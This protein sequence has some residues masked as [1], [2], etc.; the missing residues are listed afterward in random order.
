MIMECFIRVPSIVVILSTLLPNPIAPGK[1]AEINKQYRNLAS[2]LKNDDRHIIL[3][4]MD[5]GFITIDEIWDGTHPNLSG[6]RKMAAV[7]HRAIN[8]ADKEGWLQKPSSD[9]TFQDGTYGNTCPKV[10]GSGSSDP[11]SGM[12]ILTANSGLIYDDGNYV[13]RS[14]EMGIIHNHTDSETNGGGDFFLAQLVN[15]QNV[16]R[17]GERDDLVYVEK[18]ATEITMFINKGDGTFGPPVKIDVHDSCPQAG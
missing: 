10:L 4:E 1:V 18:S 6:F 16:V 11:R 2:K 8:Q 12:Q 9:V 5:D 3:A 13:H 14:T 7:W 17:G 15:L